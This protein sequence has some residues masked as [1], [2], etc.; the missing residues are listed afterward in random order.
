MSSIERKLS[1]RGFAEVVSAQAARKASRLKQFKYPTSSESVGRSNYYVSALAAIRHHH[2]GDVTYVKSKLE[3]LAEG[4]AIEQDSR[5]KT[6][7]TQNYRVITQYLSSFGQR[8]LL[9]QPG[10]SLYYTHNGLVVSA[11]P[12]LVVIENGEMKLLKLNMGKGDFAGGVPAIL[13]HVLYEAAVE[14]GLPVLPSGVE[15]IQVASGTKITGPKN[16]FAPKDVLNVA[17]DEVL[18]LWQAA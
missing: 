11:R 10:K 8:S 18:T 12:D 15:C 17:C 16:G 7:F 14:Q 2:K 5:R 9:V 4:A 13:L 1:M 6:Q 3:V